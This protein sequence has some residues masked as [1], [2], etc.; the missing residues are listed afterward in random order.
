[1]GLNMSILPEEVKNI[2]EMLSSLRP[3][4]SDDFVISESILEIG[5]LLSRNGVKGRFQRKGS[6]VLH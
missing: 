1:M 5:L 4:E 3:T 2:A 6:K